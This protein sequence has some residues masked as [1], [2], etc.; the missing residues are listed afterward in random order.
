MLRCCLL[1]NNNVVYQLSSKKELGLG[2]GTPG[3]ESWPSLEA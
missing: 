2:L 3:T 1:S